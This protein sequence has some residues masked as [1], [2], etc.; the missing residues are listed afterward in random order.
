MLDTCAL[1]WLA[2]DD[3]QL[4]A[5]ARKSIG[6]AGLVYCSAVSGFEIAIKWRRGK[7]GL[8]ATPDEWLTTIVHHHGLTLIPLTADDAVRAPL[9]PDAH[10][11]PCDR[12]IIAT[13]MRLAAPIVTADPRFKA[14]DVVII[15]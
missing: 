4:S 11:D 7:L 12:F 2:S 10:R 6:E 13:A 8:P 5:T 9:L 1:L 14:Y 3:G 15:D